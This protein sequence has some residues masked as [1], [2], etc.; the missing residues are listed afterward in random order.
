MLLGRQTTAVVVTTGADPSAESE[1]EWYPV[2]RILLWI[3]GEIS[4]PDAIDG[5]WAAAER[6]GL[7]AD[8]GADQ[9][10][11]FLADAVANARGRP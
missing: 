8:L 10:Q 3:A 7:V 2:G 6:A 5:A 11:R 4:F 9:V 1:V